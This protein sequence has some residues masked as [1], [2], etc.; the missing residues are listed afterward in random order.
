MEETDEQEF[1]E[2]LGEMLD[3]AHGLL[4]QTDDDLLMAVAIQAVTV[5]EVVTD[6]FQSLPEGPYLDGMREGISRT[7]LS[8]RALVQ[9]YLARQHNGPLTIGELLHAGTDESEPV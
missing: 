6:D 2:Y 7:G 5:L 1:Y 4:D 3:A 8:L 9:A